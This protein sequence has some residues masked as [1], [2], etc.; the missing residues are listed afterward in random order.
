MKLFPVKQAETALRNTKSTSITTKVFDI[1]F[2]LNPLV[3]GL[4]FV[5]C[6]LRIANRLYHLG[7]PIGRPHAVCIG[8][9]HADVLQI[10]EEW[11]LRIGYLS[12]S[13]PRITHDL[14]PSLHVK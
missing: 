7:S 13:I 9:G 8:G 5:V 10:K 12:G 4:L 3:D 14:I 6:L 2:T 11:E 1:T